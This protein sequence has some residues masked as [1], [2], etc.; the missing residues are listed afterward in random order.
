MRYLKCGEFCQYQAKRLFWLVLP[1]AL[2]ICGCNSGKDAENLQFRD[3]VIAYTR[4]LDEAYRSMN[5]NPLT[6][7][8][9]PERVFKVYHHM[10]ALGE[11]RVKMVMKQ[12]RLDFLKYNRLSPD[13]T[14]VTADERWYCEY[15]SVDTGEKVSENLITYV[16]LYQLLRENGRWLVNDITVKESTETNKHSGLPFFQRP[17]GIAPGSPRTEEAFQ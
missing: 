13:Q 17:P 3:T 5:S 9:T 8:A 11:G 6:R 7:I 4:L 14:E 16:V 15:F 2:T 12:E 10:A 1:I